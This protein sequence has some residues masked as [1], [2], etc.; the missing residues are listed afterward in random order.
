MLEQAWGRNKARRLLAA[1]IALLLLLSAFS[2][3]ARAA[4][5]A[6]AE[7]AYA[8]E[9][10]GT[11]SW[12]GVPIGGG[13]YVT[14]IVVHPTEPDLV[15]IRTDVGGI[16]RWNETTASWKQLVG[17]ADRSQI[18]LY[19]GESIAIDPTDPDVVYAALG[20][21]DYLRPSDIYKSTDRGET[22]TA[23]GLNANGA[24]VRMA[25]NGG[26][27]TAGERLAVDPN[28]GSV[29]F[30]GSRYDG[31]FRSGEGAAPGSWTRVAGLPV[32][33]SSPHGV[34]F[35]LFDPSSGSPGEGSAVIYAGVHNSGVYRSSDYGD[36]WTLLTG[37]PA[38]PLRAAVDP[39][40]KLYV[41]HGAGLAAYESGAWSDRTPAADTGK[42][43][44]SIAIDPANPD[45]LIAARKLDSHGNPIYRSE[46]GGATWETVPYERDIRVPWM[47]DWHWS[48]ATSALA[49]DPFRPG[50]VWLTD[51][52][53]PWRTEDIDATPTVWRND[54]KGLETVVN[55]ANL[56]SPPGGG[57]ILHSGIADNGG[58]RSPIAGRSA[59]F[60]LLY[61]NGRHPRADDDRHRRAAARP[62]L[63]RPRRDVRLERRRPRGSR[64]GR[65]FGRRRHELYGVRL[66]ALQ[67]SA[68]RQSRG[69]G[70]LARRHRMGAADGRYPL[71]GRPRRDLAE[72]GR[73][74]VRTADGQ[75]YF[76]QLLSASVG[77]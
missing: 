61:G 4:S 54:A 68:R 67:G 53:Y 63:R 52:Y 25:A 9:E 76:R 69:V 12:G 19:G 50:R 66:A 64:F 51:W 24:Q 3:A 26:N 39:N 44:G 59:G 5:D 57:T 30:F 15:Y 7:A 29:V 34:T 17:W 43:F 75:P 60:H 11:Y 77:R 71:Y 22:W 47:P 38:Q 8:Q 37:S 56:V 2:P 55:V 13:G 23:T 62:E 20:K 45:R 58:V 1:G 18:N 72:G 35:V 28:D 10:T 16:Y 42:T 48:S 65:L 73:R 33:G 21:Y 27:R 74:A 41:A 14:G 40:G 31:L 70:D 6:T 36:T 49:F 46:D 32:A